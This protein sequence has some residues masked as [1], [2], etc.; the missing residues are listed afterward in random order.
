MTPSSRLTNMVQII[1]AND[2]TREICGMDPQEIVGRKF[3][4]VNRYCGSIML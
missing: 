3:D 4:Q 2:A 1:A